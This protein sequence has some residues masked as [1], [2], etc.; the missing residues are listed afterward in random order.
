MEGFGGTILD[1]MS[2]ER[3]LTT[4]ARHVADDMPRAAGSNAV[5]SRGIDQGVWL[6]TEMSSLDACRSSSLQG[7]VLAV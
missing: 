6:K 4:A 3:N 7:F 2:N 5:A 1:M